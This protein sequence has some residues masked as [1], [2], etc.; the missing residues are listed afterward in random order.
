MANIIRRY[1]GREV[2]QGSE[3]W[4]PFRAVRD[5]FR[6]DPFREIEAALGGEYRT[7]E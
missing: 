3:A 7:R 2:A 6:W 4:D 5:A 1:S